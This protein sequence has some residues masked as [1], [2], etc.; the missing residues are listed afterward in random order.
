M[1]DGPEG[2][3]A[4]TLARIYCTAE[5]RALLTALLGIEREVGA[6]LRA[7]LDHAIAHARLAWWREEFSRTAAGRP[8]H[9]L[10]REVAGQLAARAPAKASGCLEA[11]A[12]LVDLAEW[13]LARATFSARAELADYCE[14]WSAAILVPL[15]ADPAAAAPVR[16][17]GTSLR[18]IELLLSLP[19]DAHAGRVRLPLDELEPLGVSPGQLA[20]PPWSQALAEL[21]RA[22]HGE[23]RAALGAGVASLAPAAQPSLRGVIVWAALG[24]R[25]SARSVQRLPHASLTGEHHA[26]LDGWHA[27][28]AA[29]RAATGHALL[30]RL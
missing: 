18:E 17:I 19:T 14:R 24:A 30:P 25:Y 29:R 1:P 20:R 22:R 11:L 10:T 28:R 5:Q 2:G 16:A 3:G 4:R 7:G 12:G 8:G 27:W 15:A 6:S 13:D 9:P 23:L 21:L 26:L